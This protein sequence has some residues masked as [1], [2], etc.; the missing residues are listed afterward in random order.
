[1]LSEMSQF[2]LTEESLVEFYMVPKECNYNP[3]TSKGKRI[4]VSSDA[5]E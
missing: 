3:L 1:M 4:F 5:D 2:E